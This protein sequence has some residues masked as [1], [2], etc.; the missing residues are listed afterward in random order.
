MKWYEEFPLKGKNTIM[1]LYAVFCPV[2]GSRQVPLI[3]NI[4]YID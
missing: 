3:D 2:L 1:S 4:A